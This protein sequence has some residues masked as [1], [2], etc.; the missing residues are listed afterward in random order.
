[1][2]KVAYA[3]ETQDAIMALYKSLCWTVNRPHFRRLKAWH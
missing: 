2:V 3:S 1:M